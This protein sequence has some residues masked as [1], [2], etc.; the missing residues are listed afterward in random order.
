MT[1]TQAC[2]WLYTKDWVAKRFYRNSE[3]ASL[4][5]FFWAWLG[6]HS[7]SISQWPSVY[8]PTCLYAYRHMGRMNAYLPSALFLVLCVLTGDT[9]FQ[10]PCRYPVQCQDFAEIGLLSLWLRISQ[11]VSL[12]NSLSLNFSSLVRTEWLFATRHPITLINSLCLNLDIS[13]N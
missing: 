3:I 8:M 10:V 4:A 2:A 9:G 6:M 5:G 1:A 12:R 13:L 11:G 7:F